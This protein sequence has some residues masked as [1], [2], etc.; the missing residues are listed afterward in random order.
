MD[1]SLE[2]IQDK[3]RSLW[4]GA[5]KDYMHYCDC[6]ELL[7]KEGSTDIELEVKKSYF[8][9]KA[10]GVYEAV[11]LIDELVEEIR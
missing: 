5:S 9:G 8:K 1:N 2:Q 11:M 3:L 10:S 6:A 7:K 4:F